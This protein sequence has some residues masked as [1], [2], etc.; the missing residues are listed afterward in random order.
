[1]TCPVCPTGNCKAITDLAEIIIEIVE[2]LDETFIYSPEE[3]K[4]RNI[5]D[6]IKETK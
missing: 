3:T 6:H 2:K 1:M 5:I 4:L